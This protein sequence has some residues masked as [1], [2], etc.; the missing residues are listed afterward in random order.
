LGITNNLET[1]DVTYRELNLRV[2][3]RRH[4]CFLLSTKAIPQPRE[5]RSNGYQLLLTRATLN[6]L[7]LHGPCATAERRAQRGAAMSSDPFYFSGRVETLKKFHSQVL[8]LS[9]ENGKTW[10]RSEEHTSELQSLRHLVCR[11]LLEKK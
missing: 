9:G 1:Q 5:T 6:R 11:L 3:L 10:E 4:F 7:S 8:P 2:G